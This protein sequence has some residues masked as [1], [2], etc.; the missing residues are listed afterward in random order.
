MQVT[1]RRILLAIKILIKKT[2]NNNK[3]PKPY[4]I[5]VTSAKSAYFKPNHFVIS[6]ITLADY[7]S[8]DVASEQ[9]PYDSQIRTK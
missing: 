6:A 1:P 4:C 9:I 8:H 3:N 2:N 7:Q 5:L